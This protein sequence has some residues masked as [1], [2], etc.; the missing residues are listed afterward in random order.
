MGRGRGRGGEKRGASRVTGFLVLQA[1]RPPL[2]K[3]PFFLQSARPLWPNK[4]ETPG[5]LIPL[6]KPNFSSSPHF[7]P[8]WA[9]PEGLGAGLGEGAVPRA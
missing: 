9:G 7:P 5:L 4:H 3:L 8:L 1:R 2:R 6:F